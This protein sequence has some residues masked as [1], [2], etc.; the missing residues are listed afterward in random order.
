MVISTFFLLTSITYATTCSSG[1]TYK[2]ISSYT[3][4]AS[5]SSNLV[6]DTGIV[7]LP[8]ESIDLQ[9]VETYESHTTVQ[10]HERYKAVL[11]N[12]GET[13]YTTDIDNSNPGS[14]LTDLGTLDNT[15]GSNSAL[16][17]RH[18][19]AD[20][21]TLSDPDIYN[22]VTLEGFCYKITPAT[23]DT[24]YT[25]LELDIY[26][27]GEN[28][29]GSNLV[30][31]IDLIFDATAE[32]IDFKDVWTFNVDTS[33]QEHEQFLIEAYTTSS[34]TSTGTTSY[35]I[36]VN[37]SM[38][39]N[40][41]F[42]DV[43][44]LNI[45]STMSL[46]A[47]HYAKDNPVSGTN[48]VS[49]KGLCYKIM[50]NSAPTAVPDTKTT[51]EDTPTTITVL[52][53]D[54][55]PDGD[56]L[57]VTTL[58]QPSHGTAVKN[59]NGTITYTPDAN[60]NGTD[61]F[62]YSITDGN[63]ET[64][65]TTVTVTVTPVNDA[66]VAVDDTTTTQEDQPVN[67]PVVSNDTDVDGDIL[68]VKPGSLTTPANGTVS[69]NPDGTVKYTPD[70]NF[71]GTDTFEYTVQDG[72]GGEDTATVTVTVL[73]TPDVPV[74][75]DDSFTLNEDTTKNGTL[76]TN[77]IPS[78]D[79]G[80]V[81]SKVSDPSNGTV[82]VNAAGTFSYVPNANFNGL[83]S[84][85]YKIRDADGDESEATVILDVKSVNDAPVA[86]DDT[87]T[88]QEDQPVNIPVVSNDTDVDGDILTV[89]PG[90]LT[91]PANGTVSINP[92]GTVKYTPDAN[93]NGTDTFEYTV[94]DGNGG[95]DTAT[96]TVTVG[97]VNDRVIAVDDYE[98]TDEEVAVDINVSNNDID[99][100]GDALT[101]DS[102]TQPN[103]GTVTQNTDGTLK[104][105]PDANFDGV[106][107][108]TYVITDGSTNDSAF[109]VITVNDTNKQ[110]IA[111]DDDKTTPEDTPT[112]ITV[113]GNDTDP[114]G[115][116]LTV[117]PGSLTTPAN[118]TVVINPDGTV[119]YTPDAN[120]NGTDTFEYTVQDGNGGEDTATVTVTVTPVNDAPV[121]VDD[122][123]STPED[124][125]IDIN[126][127]MNDIDV[128]GDILIVD[129][130]T[131]PNNGVVT[132][133]ADGTLKYTPDANFNGI[134]IF[135][136]TV[137][138]GVL[139]DTATV[140]VT[141]VPVNDAPIAVDDTNETDRNTSITLGLEDIV[142]SN[143]SD[144]DGDTLS[145]V[146]VSN[147]VNGTVILNGDGTV[148][149]APDVNYTGTGQ[150]DYTISDGNGG[151][152][153]ATVV[154]TINETVFPPD[155]RPI[156]T[157]YGGIVAGEGEHIIS[158][159]ILIRDLI[160]NGQYDQSNPLVV[161]VPK[162]DAISLVY[163]ST[164]TSFKGQFVENY[165]W[166]FDDSDPFDYVFTFT[167]INDHLSRTRFAIEG[168]FAVEV[169]EIG[170]FILEATIKA[171][172][173][174]DSNIDNNSDRD[175]IEKRLN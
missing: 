174:G 135:E 119:K 73:D 34:G 88:T 6:V 58:T 120:F 101:V 151:F 124:T 66:P 150:F 165:L 100:D 48:S 98:T 116:T 74:A 152:D 131:Q 43:G 158:F 42:S 59:A 169:G 121:A 39:N 146:S 145:I 123:E 18:Y 156:L 82:T 138:D 56:T 28:N 36:D 26:S 90:S 118:G 9:D 160:D 143:D 126:V 148:T 149:F 57:S 64:D 139:T 67:I 13:A 45:D 33:D 15:S 112:T 1:Y 4:G 17:F 170:K 97:S 8:K 155:Y 168:T 108:F 53:N 12:A 71:N 132:Q 65:T 49:L 14:V 25:F 144:V 35:T 172:T 5:T 161:R 107:F 95:E 104:Y 2:D 70:A 157:V 30:Q 114:E 22:S 91:T 137:T 62:T 84:F 105:T 85:T 136:Y 20:H 141:V 79:G 32:S 44:S 166:Q 31:D 10:P 171:G 122:N 69:I 175:T 127:T 61:V 24:G 60:Y 38:A 51:P 89:K 78:T 164:M 81:W 140:T 55:D 109:V 163:D 153:T 76:I 162:N 83:D 159:D 87:T 77:D 115:D 86:V 75:N 41:Q 94:Q 117:K 16:T 99:D 23:C 106:D 68:T 37:N 133:N 134:D 154:I 3:S 27:S 52:G 11:Q 93:F 54:T 29:G 147:E 129:V 130:F 125:P 72:N 80:N 63:G 110:P 167:G 103:N 47:R 173:G 50:S 128:D 113:L 92:D 142:L 96:V 19:A 40:N 111:M 46:R 7:L 21:D 102:F